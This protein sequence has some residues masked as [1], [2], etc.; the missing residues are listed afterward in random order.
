MPSTVCISSL[1][2][3]SR[4]A[5]AASTLIKSQSDFQ[6]DAAYTTIVEELRSVALRGQE[7]IERAV[8]IVAKFQELYGKSKDRL[9]ILAG[10]VG[11]DVSTLYAWRRQVNNG[12]RKA[13]K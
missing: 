10:S 1:H 13:F 11:V 3:R 6:T 8:Q 2:L 7:A 12:G 9:R 4:P 5:P